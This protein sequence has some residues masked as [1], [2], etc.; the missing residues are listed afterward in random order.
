MSII[1]SNRDNNAEI[2]V[3]CNGKLFYIHISPSHF[4]NSPE[5]TA[6]YL[7]YLDVVRSG[8]DEIDGL[9]ESDFD[10][11]ATVPFEPLFRELAPGPALDKITILTLNDFL[12][13]EFFV[14]AL[15]AIDERLVPR[16]IE[17]SDSGHM[18]PGA[19]LGSEFRKSL[20]AWTASFDP[21][22]VTLSFEH[23]E[24]ALVKVPK[25]VYVDGGTC[26]FK[27]F[28]PGAPRLAQAELVAYKK[29][30][31]AELGLRVRVCHLRGVVQN[32]E[33]LLMGMLLTYIDQPRTLLDALWGD[34]SLALRQRWAT[35]VSETVAELHKANIVWG[36]AKAENVLIDSEN[37]AWVTDF[38]GGY[39]VGWVDAENAGTVPGDLQGLA[40]ILDFL[41]SRQ[42]SI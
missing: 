3:R 34:T 5:T 31:E 17:T 19:W 30:A 1:T 16:R 24:D 33:G 38:G 42:D 18:P 6:Q 13:P 40:R 10:A 21:S 7:A 9:F 12:F 28:A 32:N 11:W 20:Q 27:A 26:F 29:I 4:Y 14:C 39:T 8:E 41:N 35:Q 23:P 25:K 15:D 36:D 2:I 37:N 22:Q